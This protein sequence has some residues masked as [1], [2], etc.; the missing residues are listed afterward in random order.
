MNSGINALPDL[1]TELFRVFDK[2]TGKYWKNTKGK[3]VW[4]KSGH[5]KNAWCVSN[6]GTFNEQNRFV[7]HCFQHSGWEL[8]NDQ[9]EMNV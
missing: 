1:P 4:A 6:R 9:T 2:E 3:T 5:A 7:V 8:V